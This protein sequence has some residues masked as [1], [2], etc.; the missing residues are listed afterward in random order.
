M[1][2]NAK[3][4]ACLRGSHDASRP[5]GQAVYMCHNINGFDTRHFGP[6]NINPIKN[7]P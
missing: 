1:L 7:I 3:V 5:R 4:P 2:I 6:V